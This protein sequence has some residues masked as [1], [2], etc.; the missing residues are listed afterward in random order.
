MATETLDAP[1]PQPLAPNGDAPTKAEAD[2][3][4]IQ[5]EEQQHD[6]EISDD[7][8]EQ[9]NCGQLEENVDREEDA[10]EDED[11]D[12]DEEGEK[13]ENDVVT[14][15]KSASGG[16]PTRERK[17]VERYTVSSPHKF[18]GYA[19]TK[20][21]S[22][23]QGNGTQ[24]KDIP[25]VAFKLSKRKV[26]DNLRSLHSILFAKKAKAQTLKRNIGMFSGYVW[27]ENEEKQ[28]A[29]VKER[30]DKCVKEKL[31]DFCDVLNLQINKSSL[32]KEELSAKLLEFLESPHATTDVLL[33][34]KEKKGK[35]RAKK[36][37][38]RKSSGG[39][40]ENP[41]K[42]QKQS[43]ENGKKRKQSSDSEED[44]T[45]EP[46]DA[47]ISSQEDEEDG[48]HVSAPKSESDCEVQ[49]SQSDEEENK[50]T[51][52]K[53]VKEDHSTPV[54][55][56]SPEKAAKS[57]DKMPKKSTSASKRQ[58]T[59]GESRESKQKI[60]NKKETGKSSK[61]VSKDQGQD[62][63]SKKANAEPT[64]EDMHAVV[65]DM[66]KEVDFNTA[67]LS[68]I[69]KK[70]GIHFGLDLMHR[71]AEVKDII[72][73]VINNMSDEENENGDDEDE[74]NA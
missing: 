27:A 10:D 17:S 5:D 40:V 66:L 1:K 73:D 24:L 23:D 55:K 64:K 4:E 36:K 20:T 37:T 3:H 53:T 63:I 46:S 2:Q 51:S 29:K 74:D 48:E 15:V 59:D 14:P 61:S 21:I 60:A 9:K 41:S 7:F 44:D 22:I 11:E 8:P 16:R 54:K 18:P 30:L 65:V 31:I 72:T 26:D 43:S 71:K 49:E 13:K 25:N 38:P 70:L 68:D 62:N 47:T 39:A 69:L 57:N 6:K 28:R 12:E 42:K 50:S 56:S 32:K 35:K 19:A 58:K 33:A 67:T 34:D 45:A 52:E